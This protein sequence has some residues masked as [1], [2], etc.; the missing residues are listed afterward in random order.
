MSLPQITNLIHYV[1]NLP[2]FI[3]GGR[4]YLKLSRV[5]L[6]PFPGLATP[7]K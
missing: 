4:L 5:T 1:L 7:G 2:D 6:L 3:I